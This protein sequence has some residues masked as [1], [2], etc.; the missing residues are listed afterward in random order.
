M[1]EG[2]LAC[3]DGRDDER[4]KVGQ[5]HAAVERVRGFRKHQP[6][7][8]H[9]VELRARLEGRPSAGLWRLAG[10]Q[11]AGIQPVQGKI[12]RTNHFERV[13]DVQVVREGL[14][15]VLPGVA[16]RIGGDVA[17]LPVRWRAIPVMTLQGILVVHRFVAEDISEALQP[18][19]IVANQPVPVIVA[20]LVAEMAEQGAIVLAHFGSQFLAL[21]GSASATLSV[22]RPLS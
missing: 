4:V 20:E 3:R 14:G 15:P 17:G 21:G 1:G 2:E 13:G 12:E 9:P 19:G 5:T 8:Q 6:A 18:A 7:R 10:R 11:S 16:R 22:I